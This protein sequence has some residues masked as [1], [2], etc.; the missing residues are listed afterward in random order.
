M[1]RWASCSATKNF[2]HYLFVWISRSRKIH[3]QTG[4]ANLCV[5]ERL[6]PHALAQTSTIFVDFGK[7]LTLRGVLTA[8]SP[9]FHLEIGQP[10]F[11]ASHVVFA[12]VEPRVTVTRADRCANE[13]LW[14]HFV[15]PERDVR[16]TAVKALDADH[17]I[18]TTL[19]QVSAQGPRK[20][21]D[22][23]NHWHRKLVG[24]V[25]RTACILL[26]NMASFVLG[27]FRARGALV[28]VPWQ[29]SVSEVRGSDREGQKA[30]CQG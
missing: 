10:I 19:A 27:A 22:L 17:E 13:S 16:R 25:R 26:E 28:I 5:L 11:G 23:L 8:V 2:D 15:F 14:L 21:V 30:N 18:L 24:E 7:C 29:T 20:R 1:T 12:R 3:L 4:A 9:V 6:A